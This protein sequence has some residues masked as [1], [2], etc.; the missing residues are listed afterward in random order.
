MGQKTE[1]NRPVAKRPADLP[2]MD[3]IRMSTATKGQLNTTV[4][5]TINPYKF[6]T[7]LVEIR[8][9]D[10]CEVLPLTIRSMASA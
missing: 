5:M 9:Y 3:K 10:A 2:T 7:N 6:F 4:N 1:P 8:M